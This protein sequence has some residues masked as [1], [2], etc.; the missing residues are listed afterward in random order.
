[1]IFQTDI[2]VGTSTLDVLYD[3]T[4]VTFSDDE[5]IK[6]RGSLAVGNLARCSTFGQPRVSLR[7]LRLMSDVAEA[8][9]MSVAL[10]DAARRWREISV[11]NNSPDQVVDGGYALLVCFCPLGYKSRCR[12]NE[13]LI[14][15]ILVC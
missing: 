12:T 7:R 6:Y 11:N 14:S 3:I 13:P 2:I 10:F 5:R 8:R 15:G 9:S 4:P 1:M